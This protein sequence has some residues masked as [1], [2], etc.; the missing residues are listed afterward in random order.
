MIISENKVSVNSAYKVA[1]QIMALLEKEHETDRDREHFWVIGADSQN[2]TKY[3]ELVSLGGLKGTFIEPRG[4]F[5]L[6]IMKA[7]N[8][9]ILC[10]NHPGGIMEPSKEDISMTERIVRAGNLLGVDVLD[11]IIIGHGFNYFSFAA[12]KMIS[13][14]IGARQVLPRKK[15]AAINRNVSVLQ[16]DMDKRL[17]QLEKQITA[18][19]KR[20]AA[21]VQ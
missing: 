11:H 21:A 17:D 1:I 2:N 18:H 4:I 9:I 10:H 7:V 16:K 13:Q 6:A 19:K 15:P 3:I 12:N 8:S 5:R 14:D 20:Q